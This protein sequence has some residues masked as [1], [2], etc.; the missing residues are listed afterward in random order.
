MRT[1]S[2]ARP[3]ARCGVFLKRPGSRFR[4]F[5]KAPGLLVTRKYGVMDLSGLG[6][7]TLPEAFAGPSEGGHRGA[8]R[9][10]EHP[11]RP[12][13]GPQ[14]GVRNACPPKGQL[15]GPSAEQLTESSSRTL[16]AHLPRKKTDYSDH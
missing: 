10:C 2:P 9:R 6:A 5:W 7:S 11:H 1:A 16:H 8:P 14:V 3:S 4:G 13:G 12:R 15:F